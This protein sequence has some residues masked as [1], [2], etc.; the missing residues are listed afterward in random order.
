MNAVVGDQSTSNKGL[1]IWPGHRIF[2]DPQDPDMIYITSYG[3]SLW[4]GPAKGKLDKKNKQD[5]D[6]AAEKSAKSQKKKGKDEL[7][8]R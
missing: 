2:P 5:A 7:A 4:Y 3:S 6:K 8:Q 1:G